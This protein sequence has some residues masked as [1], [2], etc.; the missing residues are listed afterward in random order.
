VERTNRALRSIAL[1]ALDVVKRK[2]VKELWDVGEN[3]D[4]ACEA[5]HRSY[6]YP[7]EDAEFYQKLQRRSEEFRAQ[8]PSGN[9]GA[10][11]LKR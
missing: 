4:T 7:D 3:L 6:W 2:D 11:P 5:C 9:T 1:E 10:K 8:T